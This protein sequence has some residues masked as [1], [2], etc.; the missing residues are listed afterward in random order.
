MI[1]SDAAQLPETPVLVLLAWYLRVLSLE[2]LA[3]SML[4][5]G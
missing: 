2:G 5:R 4:S 1:C 3:E